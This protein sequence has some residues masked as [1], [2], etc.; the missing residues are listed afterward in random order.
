MKIQPSLRA[1]ATGL[2]LLALALS[3]HAGETCPACVAA[4]ETP[5]PAKTTPPAGAPSSRHAGITVGGCYG[6]PEPQPS[7]AQAPSEPAPAGHPLRG[8][9][10][11]VL[12]ARQALLVHHEEIPGVMRE[13]TML[14]KV[15]A[16]TLAAAKKG[17][18]I[19]ATLLRKT[20]GWWLE[21]VTPAASPDP[22]S[23]P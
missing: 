21:N 7:P 11:D 13:M 9:I 6:K 3:G 18:A 20:D 4:P 2:L 10:V 12:P 8:V 14:L 5:A 15:D 22:T 1:S 17:A 23:A 19:T 16:T